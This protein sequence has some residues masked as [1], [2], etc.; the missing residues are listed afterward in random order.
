MAQFRGGP[1]SFDNNNNIKTKLDVGAY[2]ILEVM[3]SAQKWGSRPCL[4]LQLGKQERQ[5]HVVLSNRLNLEYN[6]AAEHFKTAQS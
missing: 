4:K 2:I 3:S 5:S 6:Q 1:S